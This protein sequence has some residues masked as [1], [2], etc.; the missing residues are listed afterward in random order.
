MLIIGT[1]HTRGAGYFR[2]DDRLS[3]GTLSEADIRTCTHCQKV[4]KMQEWREQGAFCHRCDAPICDQC[5]ARAAVYGCEPF[6]KKIDQYLDA[7]TKYAQCLKMAGLEVP[8][9][10]PPFI[11]HGK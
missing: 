5:G 7:T 8:D 6:L 9:R 11:T 10:L 1:P 4:I 3:G 2:N